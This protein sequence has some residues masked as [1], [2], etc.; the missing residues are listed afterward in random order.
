M[1]VNAL[2]RATSPYLRQ[3]ADNPV[4]WQQWTADAL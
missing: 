1:A 4:H 3:H 2:G